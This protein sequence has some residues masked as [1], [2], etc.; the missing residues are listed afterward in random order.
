MKKKI[1]EILKSAKANNLDDSAIATTIYNELINPQII[2][3]EHFRKQRDKHLLTK[4]KSKS[5][6]KTQ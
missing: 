1:I 4:T 6:L 2:A 3:K 5:A